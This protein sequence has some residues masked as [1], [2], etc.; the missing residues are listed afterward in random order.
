MLNAMFAINKQILEQ[1]K[2][3]Y[4]S[5][6]T[7]LPTPHTAGVADRNPLIVTQKSKQ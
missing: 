2:L 3:A 5:T 6:G 4:P 1:H 7:K